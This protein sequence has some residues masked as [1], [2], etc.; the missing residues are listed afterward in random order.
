MLGV[1]SGMLGCCFFLTITPQYALLGSIFNISKV[2]V[3]WFT[4]N[5]RDLKEVYSWFAEVS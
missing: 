3:I 2:Q 5:K 4:K 1:M